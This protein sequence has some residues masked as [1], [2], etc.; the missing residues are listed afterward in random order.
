MW[1][2]LNSQKNKLCGVFFLVFVSLIFSSVGMMV[3][4]FAEEF[5]HL[6][7]ATTFI[8]TP[9]IF[10]GGVFHSITMMPAPLRWITAFNPLFYM[11]NGMRYGMLGRSDEPVAL[12]VGIILALFILLFSATV[13]LFKIGYKL[14]K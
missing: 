7:M 14:R 3:A 10:F 1:M 8:I 11:I 2:I 5:E 13:Y 9:L 4:L 12:C 6:S